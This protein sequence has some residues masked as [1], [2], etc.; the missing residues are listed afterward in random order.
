MSATPSVTLARHVPQ[1][2]PL[3]AKGRSS[4]LRCAASRIDT[5]RGSTRVLDG[6]FDEEHLVV[7]AAAIHTEFR[8]HVLGVGDHAEWATE[9]EVVD[10]VHRH[11]SLQECP[12]STAIESSAEELC[13]PRLTREYVNDLESRTVGVLE[14]GEFVGE[15]HRAGTTIAVEE[16]D[17]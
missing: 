11:E 15:H 13:H 7:D 3:H 16:R 8:K 6:V 14:V 4:R 10:R 1:T 17:A 9:P 5:S 12:N 2:P